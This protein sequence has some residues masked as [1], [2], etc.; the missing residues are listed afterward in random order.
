VEVLSGAGHEVRALA[1]SP[2]NTGLLE[3]AGAE[4]VRGDLRDPE[5]MERAVSGCRRV[6][7]SAAVVSHKAHT[8]RQYRTVNVEGAELLARAAM[9][10]GVE[11]F[12]QVS[13]TGVYGP[14]T[15]GRADETTPPAPDNHYRKT[16]LAAE[17]AMLA[18]HEQDGLPVVIVRL[19]RIVG[20]RSDSWLGLCKSLSNGGMRLVG[21]GRNRWHAAHVRDVA[22]L[23]ARCGEAP[24]I[25]GE[26]YISC[27]D[28][29]HQSREVLA[30]FADALGVDRP[31]GS[32][33]AAPY[34]AVA[35]VDRLSFATVGLELGVA[36]RY[37][38]FLTDRA[39][40]NE[41][42]R[43]EL[44]VAPAK[45]IAEGIGETVDWYRKEALI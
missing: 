7:N 13:T 22:A 27:A 39:Y 24:G 31:S 14:T 3:A 15:D 20:P 38:L 25:E 10:A 9:R 37:D 29:P 19:A 36:R 11:R 18:M 2:G 6:F 32:V 26:T 28:E 41:K 34:R 33:P 42:A 1:R 16:K 12:V 17:R 44:G 23:L 4:I 8:A 30:L 35:A 5:A 40:S 21:D 43:R 45:D